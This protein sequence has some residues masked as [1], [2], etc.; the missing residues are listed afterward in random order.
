MFN[1][2]LISIDIGSKNI[3]VVIGKKHVNSVKVN[4]V[5][6]IPTPL[7]SFEDG[8]ITDSI[9]IKEALLTV[10]EI[11]DGKIKN[12][13]VTTKS[14]AIVQREIVVPKADGKEL[15]S[16]VK[17]ELDKYLPINMEEYVLQY[18]ITGNVTEGNMTKL[19]LR[20]VAY[21]KNIVESYYKLFKEL[22]L[23]PV[24]M[25]ISS[26]SVVKL[27][28]G[29]N[30]L[31]INNENYDSSANVIF[32]DLGNENCNILF[33]SDRKY[34]FSRIIPYGGKFIN[35]NIKKGLLVSMEQ[36][37]EIK[38]KLAELN[39]NSEPTFEMVEINVKEALRILTSEID[40]IIEFYKNKNSGS[41]IDKIILCG[42]GSNLLSIED[43]FSKALSI[44]TFK[45]ESISSVEM[46]RDSE[47]DINM[48]LNAIGALIRL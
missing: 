33:T 46:P 3:K 29:K 1:Q 41:K 36:A 31:D 38:L 10:P 23:K 21:P 39:Q 7:V 45:L 9:K 32:I 20:V 4:K 40:R 35:M 24:A 27:I 34:E 30:K 17:Y 48:Y 12:T 13:V 8:V 47:N 5:Y 44:P 16:V 2:Q 6:T 25:D 15:D 19:K 22:K 28:N 11:R 42:G 43:Y 37:E 26:N 18:V 14:T